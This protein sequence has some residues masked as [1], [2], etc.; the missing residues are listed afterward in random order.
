MARISDRAASQTLSE[1]DAIWRQTLPEF[2]IDRV[3]IS[4]ALEDSYVDAIERSNLLTFFGIIAAGI[5]L[6]GFLALLRTA[7]MA[8]RKSAAIRKCLGARAH[9]IFIPVMLRS[10]KPLAVSTIFAMPIGWYFGQ[11]WLAQYVER[12]EIGGVELISPLIV[13]VAVTLML[14][15]YD[16][17]KISNENPTN[18]LRAD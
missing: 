11:Q 13:L 14:S 9:Q 16:A 18:A 17:L 3:Q 5:A 7:Q 12:I 4:T 10:I 1:M 15:L 8:M 6:T 2:A